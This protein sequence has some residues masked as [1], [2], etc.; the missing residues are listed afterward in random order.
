[1]ANAG[2]QDINVECS[3]TSAVVRSL[4]IE[5]PAG[6]VKKAFDKAYNDLKKSA[7]VK[8]FRPG[9]TPRSV[10]ERMYGSSLPDEIERQL[11]SETL[12]DAIEQA[13]V[14]PVAEPSIEA[15]R[16]EPD[17]PFRYTARVEV[18]PVIELPDLKGLAAQKPKVE[19]SD[20][21]IEAE[22]ERMR[23]RNVN[24]VEEPEETEAAEGHTVTVDFVG[25][26]AGEPF[27]G[28]TGQGMDVELGKGMMVP[29]FEDQL[30]GVKA[31]DD[32][33]VEVT[34]PEDYGNEDLSGKDAV[35]ECHV[36]AV[37]RRELPE[38]D[39]EF[40]KDVGEFETLDELKEKV[41]GDFAK[42]R[43]QAAQTKLQ[44]TL[45]DALLER[46]D[47]EAPPG[48]VERQLQSQIQS[49]HQR[50]EGQVP[51]DVLH[52]QLRRMQEDG[53]PAAEKRVRE[54]LVIEAIAEAQSIEVSSDDIDARLAEMAEAQGMEVEQLRGMAEAQG[55]LDGI[56]MEL[57]DKKVYAVLAADAEIEETDPAAEAA[58]DGAEEAAA[59]GESAAE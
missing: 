11:V 12:P 4:S 59:E 6:R 28:G 57:R 1:M 51:E 10:L 40:A 31:G 14:E 49:M 17:A 36:V 27:A 34:F 37:R 26:V 9:K 41:R 20:A 2:A 38:I 5:V 52:A 24:L 8:G 43:E 45:L 48:V 13:E 19:V 58:A 55:W 32:C 56:E 33:T 16:P 50:F 30:V 44:E 46:C 15:Q 39:D 22:L 25:K 35:F 47:F 21:E 54:A 23:E 7:R 42:S 18:K 53:R 29:G 3:E